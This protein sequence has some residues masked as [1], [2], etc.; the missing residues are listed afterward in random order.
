[1]NSKLKFWSFASLISFVALISIMLF[2]SPAKNITSAIPFFA[3]LV[4][5]L[6]SIGHGLVYLRRPLIGRRG[7]NR[8]AIISVLITLMLMFRSAQTLNWIDALILL[9]VAFGLLFYSSK[10]SA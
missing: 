9:L 10:R 8:I 2:T 5:F 1:M 7:H 3:V 4:L 6:I